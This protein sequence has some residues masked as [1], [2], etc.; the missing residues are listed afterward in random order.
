MINEL[1]LTHEFL[2]MMLG[3]RRACVSLALGHFADRGL[4]TAAR[5]AVDDKERNEVVEAANGVYGGV[6]V[7]FERVFP[8]PKNCSGTFWY[9]S[10][11]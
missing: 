4:I 2:E 5:C 6:E 3:V 9:R 1:V 8:S 11:P 10:R 7:E